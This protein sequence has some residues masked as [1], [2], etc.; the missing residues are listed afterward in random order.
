[1]YPYVGRSL[2]NYFGEKDFGR[3]EEMGAFMLINK[4]KFDEK[5]YCFFEKI[6]FNMFVWEVSRP[7]VKISFCSVLR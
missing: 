4:N 2:K 7:F 6:Q 1:M 3:V 5:L